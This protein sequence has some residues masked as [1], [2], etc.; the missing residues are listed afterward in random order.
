MQ[1]HPIIYEH[2]PAKMAG[3]QAQK[4]SLPGLLQKKLAKPCLH[5][6]F[7]TETKN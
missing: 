5:S 4:N 7:K 1:K 6:I 3:W 2:L